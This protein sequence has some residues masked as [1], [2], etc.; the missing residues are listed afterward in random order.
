MTE[1]PTLPLEDLGRVIAEPARI[2]ILSELLGGPALPAGALAARLGIAPST[3]SA[4][5]A[6]LHDAGLIEVEQHG[7]SRL[8]R[9][10]D[11]AVAAAVEAL[12][13]LSGEQR[14]N[15]LASHD[16]R[17]AMREA[18]SCYDHLAGRVGV[19]VADV[20]LDRGWVREAN[21]IWILPMGEDVSELA[22]GFG[23]TLSWQHSSRPA[24]RPCP[25]WTERQPHIAGRLG[26]SLLDA[27]LDADWL[28][29]RRDDRALTITAHG[30]ERFTALGVAGL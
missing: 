25:D 29:R 10:G 20:A 3:T 27:M 1:K 30:R 7:R 19:A 8:A 16:R 11:P 12:L 2:R 28:R 21:G 17:A 22:D 14:V 6:R 5:L 23:L 18:R 13:R 26:R 24:I 9:L 4:H 15:S